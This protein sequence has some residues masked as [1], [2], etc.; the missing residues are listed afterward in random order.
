M[1]VLSRGLTLGR[2]MIIADQRLRVANMSDTLNTNPYYFL[3]K[4]FKRL[5]FKF[6]PNRYYWCVCTSFCSPVPYCRYDSSIWETS[7]LATGTLFSVEF[8][9]PKEVTVVVV[10]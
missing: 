9:L 2:F 10:F 8:V 3:Q 7:M 4:R 6:Q 5:Y 1:L